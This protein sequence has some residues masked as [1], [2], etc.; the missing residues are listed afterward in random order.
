MSDYKFISGVYLP[1]GINVEP[2]ET[3]VSDAESIQR[4][5]GGNFEV[6]T[7]TCGD[8]PNTLIVGF[9]NEV[10]A[11]VGMEYNYLATNL[12]KREIHGDC[13]IVWGLNEDNEM[14][15]DIYDV[16]SDVVKVLSSDLAESSAVAYNMAVGMAGLCNYAVEKGFA[17]EEEVNTHTLNLATDALNGNRTGSESRSFFLSML[18]AIATATEGAEEGTEEDALHQLCGILKE[19]L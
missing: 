6:I 4:L 12:F 13:V 2:E 14:D 3:I 15:G 16:P 19:T 8:I 10:G 5:V 17:T 7:T 18:D 11:I 1:K 9:I